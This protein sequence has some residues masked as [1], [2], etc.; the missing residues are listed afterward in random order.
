MMA[1]VGLFSRK[2]P[3]RA[4]I[5]AAADRARARGRTKKA[6]AGYRQALESDPT[7]ASLNVKLAPL[8]AR[9]GDD[10]AGAACF[11][12]AA[13]THL[14]AG[15]TDRA[16]AVVLA[17]TGVF[18]LDAG[19]RL[20]LARL[21]VL[22][23]RRLDAVAALLGGGRA[24]ARSGRPEAA[25]SLLSRALEIE[26]WHLDTGLALA[27]VL[28]RSGR[29]DESRALLAGLEARQKGAALRRIAWT[30]FRVSPGPRTLW[31]FLRA[32]LAGERATAGG[33]GA[34]SSARRAPKAPAGGGDTPGAGR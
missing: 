11:R 1:A 15:F 3:T 26:P 34:P 17:A 28:A 12:T 33:A 13:K 24:L 29:L 7:D 8:L 31:R 2:A 18:P 6:V 4:E 10:D 32:A 23:G 14:T 20:E 27:P 16:A 30:G 21:N 25:L 19:F 22:R 9:L 5:V